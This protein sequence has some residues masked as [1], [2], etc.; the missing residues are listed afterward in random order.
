MNDSAGEILESHL[1]FRS[2]KGFA[3]WVFCGPLPG[4]QQQSVLYQASNYAKLQAEE[5]LF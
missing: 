5:M 4:S 2:A 3:G 1:E